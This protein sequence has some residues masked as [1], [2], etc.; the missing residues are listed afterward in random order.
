MDDTQFDI[1]ITRLATTR[2]SRLQTL[3]GL[4]VGGVAALSGVGR[5]RE[6][7]GAADTKREKTIRMCH[8]GDG[9]AIFGT[10]NTNSS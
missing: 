9:F 2:L 6:E 1:L 10:S 3:R 7:A 8:R 4:A 5:T